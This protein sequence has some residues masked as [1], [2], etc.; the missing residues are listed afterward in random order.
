MAHYNAG[1]RGPKYGTVGHLTGLS[2]GRHRHL[3]IM[4]LSEITATNL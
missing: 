2:T 3:R 1:P 4:Y